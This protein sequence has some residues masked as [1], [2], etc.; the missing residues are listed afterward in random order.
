MLIPVEF[1]PMRDNGV[2]LF[3]TKQ[4]NTKKTRQGKTKQNTAGEKKENHGLIFLLILRITIRDLEP[5]FLLLKR[6]IENFHPEHTFSIH[7]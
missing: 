1:F 5:G 6:Q 4:N 3:S 7:D 2:E